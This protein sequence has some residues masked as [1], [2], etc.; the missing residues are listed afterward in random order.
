MTRFLLILLFLPALISAQNL[1]QV[2]APLE[3]RVFFKFDNYPSDATSYLSDDKKQII[4]KIQNTKISAENNT[5]VGKGNVSSIDLTYKDNLLTIYMNLKEQSGYTIAPMK[6]IN[7]FAV[8]TFDWSKIN[9]QEDLYRNALLAYESGLNKVALDDLNKSTYKNAN[10]IA[11]DILLNTKDYEAA[12]N[13]AFKA[14]NSS[15]M[16]VHL[17]VL[18][19]IA[20]NLQDSVKAEVL[21][22]KLE[23]ITGISDISLNKS[24]KLSI[25]SLDNQFENQ[26]D[27]LELNPVKEKNTEQLIAEE[28]FKNI[29]ASDSSTA[30]DNDALNSVLF[31]DFYGFPWWVEYVLYFFLIAILLVVYMY[32]RWRNKQI[33][34]LKEFSEKK[35]KI[36]E[37]KEKAKKYHKDTKEVEDD[38]EKGLAERKKKHELEIQ[39]KEK[40]S[41]IIESEINSELVKSSQAKSNFSAEMLRAQKLYSEQNKNVSKSDSKTK[42]EDISPKIEDAKTTRAKRANKIEQIID[43]IR[44]NSIPETEKEAPKTKD[45][46]GLSAKMQLAM[47]ITEQEL[48][49]KNK[50][51]SKLDNLTDEELDKLAQELGTGKASIE[52]KKNMQDLQ[53]NQEAIDRL[54]KKFNKRE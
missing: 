34:A 41:E 9:K 14:Y 37:R 51:L 12:V 53:S 22:S 38:I 47:K 1:M 25:S 13:T 40:A 18:S 52:T 7:M 48:R 39:N 36:D 45:Y 5:F 29:F 42:N 20:N 50:Q 3:N 46:S 15:N 43:A 31:K 24:Y 28:K 4:I 49:E 10:D 16:P 2:S 30:A 21:V 23:N 54:A 6:S 35:R 32:L 26:L 33:L 17:A 44:S 19:E 27:S 11:A 8:E